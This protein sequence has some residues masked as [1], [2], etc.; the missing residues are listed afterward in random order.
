M[1]IFIK[2]SWL[3]CVLM[4]ALSPA[5]AALKEGAQ[6]PRFT[7][8]AAQGGEV[9]NYSLQDALKNGP[10]VVYFY[11]AAFTAGCSLQARQFAL[12][13][14][15]FKAA[16]ASI[17]GVSLDTLEE[18]KVFSADPETCAGK[19]PV[20][21]D[22]DGKT[23]TAFDLNVKAAPDSRKN[24]RGSDINHGLVERNTF[25]IDNRG[26]VVATLGGL[27]P[28]DHVEQALSVVQRIKAD[29]SGQSIAQPR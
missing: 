16:G 29:Q 26:R 13:L 1:A 21:S 6:A 25:V 27:T 12:K 5:Q 3:V 18:L 8:P 7:L 15:Q 4:I 2:P 20:A 14:N 24:S 22:A 17:V 11:P 23:A 28:Q 10:V 19:V 9:F